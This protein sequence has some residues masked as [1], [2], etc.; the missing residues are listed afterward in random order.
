MIEKINAIRQALKHECYLPALALA[1]T[2]PDIGGSIEY[3]DYI[4]KKGNRLVGEQYK[5]WFD[6][7]V[8]QYYADP[9]GWTDDF[10]QAKK[11]YFDGKMCYNLRCSFLHSGNSDIDDFG[12]K[13]DA[14]NRYSYHFELCI[15]GCDSIGTLW[16]SP[17]VNVSKTLKLKTVRIDLVSLCE[18]LLLA[19]EEYYNH[20]GRESFIE[21]TIEVIDILKTTQK[22]QDLNNQEY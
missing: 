2:L 20:K 16:T 14:E 21:H 19:A 3:P 11:P 13:E 17:Q 6:E 4:N 15:N 22:I 1:L 8:N 9:S 7:W 12:E 5:A 18:N 10:K